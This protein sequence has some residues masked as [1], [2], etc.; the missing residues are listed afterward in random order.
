[1]Q[2]YRE[3]LGQ[4][5]ELWAC[6][7][8]TYLSIN[9]TVTV[10]SDGGMLWYGG[11]IGLA[12]RAISASVNTQTEPSARNKRPRRSCAARKT[13][14]VQIAGLLLQVVGHDGDWEIMNI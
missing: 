6:G 12:T 10:E 1:M 2:L 7:A 3:V 8:Q 9:R 14:R 5:V 4:R 13:G 11:V